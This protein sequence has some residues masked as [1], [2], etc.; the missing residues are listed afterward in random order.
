MV[1]E[2]APVAENILKLSAATANKAVFFRR[3]LYQRAVKKSQ[4]ERVSKIVPGNKR[5]FGGKLADMCKALKD[6]GQVCISV[7]VIITKLCLLQLSQLLSNTGHFK[8]SYKSKSHHNDDA[9][10]RGRG[11]GSYRGRGRGRGRGAYKSPGFKDKH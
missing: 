3:S 5:L 1:K 7:L 11:G 8:K 9:E 6:G 4:K 10:G 2:I